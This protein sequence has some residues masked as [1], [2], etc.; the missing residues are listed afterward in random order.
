M[1]LH[2]TFVTH[3]NTPLRLKCIH[4]VIL[5]K[6]RPIN[7][8]FIYE[9]LSQLGIEFSRSCSCQFPFKDGECVGM[10]ERVRT[11]T[12]IKK[13]IKYGTV[14]GDNDTSLLTPYVELVLSKDHTVNVCVRA[15]YMWLPPSVLSETYFIADKYE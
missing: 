11:V 3:R 14:W 8:S 6:S 7:F 10:F 4:I 12:T 2:C 13:I 9:N 1:N 15:I 5:N